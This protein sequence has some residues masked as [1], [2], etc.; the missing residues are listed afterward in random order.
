MKSLLLLGV[1][2]ILSLHTTAQGR[3]CTSYDDYIAGNWIE[4]PDL[5]FTRSKKPKKN[6]DAA[7]ILFTTKD[8]T[9]DEELDNKAVFIQCG[10]SLFINLREFRLGHAFFTNH[11]ALA[12]PLS[13]NKILFISSKPQESKVNYVT[14]GPVPI[15]FSDKPSS[16][17]YCFIIEDIKLG[18]FSPIHLINDESITKVLK[19]HDDVI[20]EYFFSEKNKKKREKSEYILPLLR[21]AGILK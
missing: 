9:T 1:F 8:K 13:N 14:I 17:T 2:F 16:N 15:M 12:Y 11:Y 21:K 20:D 18:D 3:Y 4:L 6:P 19:G 7:D 10:D 5:T